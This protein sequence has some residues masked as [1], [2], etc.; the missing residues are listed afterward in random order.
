[1]TDVRLFFAVLCP[2]LRSERENCMRAQPN[3]N[4]WNLLPHHR[5]TPRTPE[6]C[7]SGSRNNAALAHLQKAATN[8]NSSTLPI[9]SVL[10]EDRQRK[11]MTQFLWT[12]RTAG[13]AVKRGWRTL[14]RVRQDGFSPAHIGCAAGS[15]PR[16]HTLCVTGI[17]PALRS[18]RTQGAAAFA[19][20]AA[21]NANQNSNR[22]RAGSPPLPFPIPTGNHAF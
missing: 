22:D 2:F 10:V 11:S 20:H 1:M 8:D 12:I 19:A 15:R 5:R 3:K 14:A 4:N 21:T 7:T 17:F 13:A 18:P 16:A 9:R 6:R